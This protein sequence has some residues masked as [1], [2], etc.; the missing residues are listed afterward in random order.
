MPL[1][2]E[3]EPSSMFVPPY[4]RERTQTHSH[5]QNLM[6]QLAEAGEYTNCIIAEG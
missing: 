5:T 6:A 3:T 2:K 4:T 1:N